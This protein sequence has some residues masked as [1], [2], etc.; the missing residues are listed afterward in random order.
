MGGLLLRIRT[1]WEVADRTQ[2]VVTVF[3]S[4][5][6]VFLLAGTFWFAGRPKMALLYGGLSPSEMGQVVQEVQKLGIEVEYDL[7]G[8]IRVPSDRVAEVQSMLAQN[9]VAPT[10]GH[11]GNADLGSISWGVPQ[12]VEQARLSAIQEGE[13][14]KTIEKMNGVA[15][16]RVFINPGERGSFAQEDKPPTASIFITE[17]GTADLGAEQG[18]TIAQIVARAVPGLSQKEVTVA[19]QDGSMIYE[20]GDEASR[21]GSFASKGEAQSAEAKRIRR[22]LQPMLDRAFGPGTTLLTA[23]VEMDFD[24]TRI[25]KD[26]SQPSE[27]PIVTST[28]KEEYK[29]DAGSTTDGSQKG[30]NNKSEQSQFGESR[31]HEERSPAAGTVTSLALS[32]LVDSEKVADVKPVEAFLASYLKPWQSGVN[33]DKFTSSVTSTKFDTTAAADAKKASDAAAGAERMQQIFSLIPVGALILVALFVLKS[34][35]KVAKGSGN[36]VVHALPGGQVGAAQL[37]LGGG[38]GSSGG[39]ASQAQLESQIRAQ[40]AMP[41]IEVGSIVD[42]LNVPLEQIKKMAAEKPNV[43]SMLLKS[44]LLEDRR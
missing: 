30:Y 1:W 10:S 28:T 2:K 9:G 7:Q 37:A 20:G 19:T 40:E 34:L 16:A 18:K 44:W 42:R 31:V 13:I 24:V 23:R 26:I 41:E 43:V 36:V 22:E 29:G 5:F 25:V 21:L 27:T 3:G 11:A 38:S 33:A 32:V 4:A 39:T 12:S 35:A 15:S 6:L 17:S 8:N 14:A